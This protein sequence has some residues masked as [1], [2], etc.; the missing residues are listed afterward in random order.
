MSLPARRGEIDLKLRVLSC[1]SRDAGGM[2]DEYRTDDF[3]AAHGLGSPCR[4]P[5]LSGALSR[6]RQ[7]PEAFLRSTSFSAWPSPSS[8]IARVCATSRPVCGGSQPTFTTW[9][10]AAGSRGTLAYANE[11]R[12]LMPHVT[13]G[14]QVVG[15]GHAH[16]TD[17]GQIGFEADFLVLG[18]MA[19][20][21]RQLTLIRL[22][23]F[24]L[25]QFA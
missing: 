21:A 14:A 6:R 18:V 25:Q 22:R 2:A 13:L 10:F 1:H 9:A 16:R 4:V 11:Y 8:R 7:E 5:P 12:D 24:E 15:A 23:D 3:R 17:D 19:A 20:G